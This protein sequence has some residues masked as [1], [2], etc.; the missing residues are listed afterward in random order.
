MIHG[1]TAILQQYYSNNTA[2]THGMVT[3]LVPRTPRLVDI[4]G[5]PPPGADTPPPGAD[6]PPPLPPGH[7]SCL[8]T[9]V[10]DIR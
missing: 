2:L 4:P 3:H 9:E 1:I 5:T 7:S 8:G 10:V 6:N